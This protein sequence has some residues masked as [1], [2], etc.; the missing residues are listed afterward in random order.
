[1]SDPKDTQPRAAEDAGVAP[2]GG[3]QASDDVPVEGTTLDGNAV[4]ADGHT[5]SEQAKPKGSKPAG[6]GG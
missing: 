5:P 4:T 1:M 2:N 3:F 6:P